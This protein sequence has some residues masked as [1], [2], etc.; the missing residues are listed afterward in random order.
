MT[1]GLYGEFNY[2]KTDLQEA[3]NM[4]KSRFGADIHIDFS[5]SWFAGS[6]IYYVGSRMDV[7]GP[8]TLSREMARL[9]TSSPTTLSAAMRT[10]IFT[11]RPCP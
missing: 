8:F 11:T 1:I 9:R 10:A 6:E 2:F 3:W 5:D 4:P 7:L